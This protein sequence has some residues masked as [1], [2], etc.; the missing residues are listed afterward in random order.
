MTKPT[1]LDL[2]VEIFGDAG[3][4]VDTAANGEEA[5]RKIRGVRYDAVVTDVRMPRMS[6]IRLYDEIMDARPDL[7]GRVVFA[8]GDLIDPDT[9]AFLERIDART[10]AKRWTSPRRCARSKRSSSSRPA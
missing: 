4:R 10:I 7:A 6:G 1:I 8:T 5:A 3:Y 9:V 2:L